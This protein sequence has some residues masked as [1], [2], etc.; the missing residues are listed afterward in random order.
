MSKTQP[1]EI[2]IAMLIRDHQFLMQLRDD[3]PTIHHPGVWAFF[4]GHIEPNEDPE[5]GIWRELQ[6]EIAYTPPWIK[7]FDRWVDGPIA[8]NIFYGPLTV[9]LEALELN[10]GW[11]MGLWS[12]AE[13]QKGERYSEKAQQVRTIGAPHQQILLSFIEQ[14]GTA[15]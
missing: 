6:E 2:A 1:L 3:I 8:R 14:Y 12:V 11:D 7:F 5:T 15:L 4:G 13:I 10:E 9:P